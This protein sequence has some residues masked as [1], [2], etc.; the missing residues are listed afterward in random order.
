MAEADKKYPNSVHP[1]A[2]WDAVH[3]YAD[4]R[5]AGLV[6]NADG[7]FTAAFKRRAGHGI[8]EEVRFTADG[9]RIED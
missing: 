8:E 9:E 3:D 2:V 4:G 1:D 5:N 7:T 6:Q